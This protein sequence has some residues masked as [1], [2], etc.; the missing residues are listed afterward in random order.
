[1]SAARLSSDELWVLS[2]YRASELAGAL[3]FGHLAR[4]TADDQMRVFLTE[5]FAEEARHSWMW[6]ETIT[7][8]GETPVHITETYQ[9]HYAREVGLPASMTEVLL[10][11]EVFEK[12]IADH[13]Q[14]HARKSDT[15][16]AVRE[17]LQQMLIEEAG[18]VD[19]ISRRLAQY[20]REGKVDL[21]R[22]RDELRQIDQRIYRS[23][24]AY[25][26]HLWDYLG[27][28]AA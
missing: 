5:H 19:W 8:L 23:V 25:E 2:Y 22:R 6:T 20:A 11:T 27:R 4:R 16:P 26:S 7:R 14:R 28:P 17:T 12:R 15:H 24:M 10:L 3:L 9:S 18:H 21:E 1:M 13:F